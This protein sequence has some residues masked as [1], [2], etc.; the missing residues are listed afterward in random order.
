M[1]LVVS[2][3][4]NVV[5]AAVLASLRKPSPIPAGENSVSHNVGAYEEKPGGTNAQPERVGME[6]LTTYEDARALGQALNLA[7]AQLSRDHRPPYVPLL[8]EATVRNGIEAAVTAY[9]ATQ[10][11]RASD[12]QEYLANALPRIRA[13]TRDGQ[14]PKMAKFSLLYG[15]Q[16]ED[17]VSFKG[18]GLRMEMNTPGEKFEAFTLPVL[19]V[20]Y[21][22]VPR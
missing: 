15:L 20:W 11:R 3:L 21:G 12:Q 17:G 6:K 9:Q 22:H 1:A 2:L 4:L 5:L 14:W 18:F 8:E 7:K 16:N 10:N 19:D 13:I